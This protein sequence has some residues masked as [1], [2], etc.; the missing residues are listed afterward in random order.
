MNKIKLQ[1]RCMDLFIKVFCL[2]F[3]IMFL[4]KLVK[5]LIL[6]SLNV[7]LGGKDLITPLLKRI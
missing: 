1:N 3:K 2:I 7:D 5:H 4:A 6:N